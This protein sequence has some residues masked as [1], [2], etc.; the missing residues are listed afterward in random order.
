ME[1]DMQFCVSLLS[2]RIRIAFAMSTLGALSAGCD[3]GTHCTGND[4]Q[5]SGQEPMGECGPGFV[6]NDQ[7]ECVDATAPSPGPNPGPASGP[8]D[9][10]PCQ[11]AN[12]GTCQAV[13]ESYVCLCDPGFHDDGQSCV[14][15]DGC[16]TVV[17][18][19]PTAGESVGELYIRGE[20]N[21]WSQADKMQRR[22]DGSFVATLQLAA[23][24]WGYKLYD[25]S[26]DRW[27]EDPSNPY[28][29]WIGGIRNSRLHVRDCN[30]PRLLLQARPQ[31]TANSVSWQVRFVDGPGGGGLDAPSV[32]VTRNGVSVTASVDAATSTI[33]L[34][35]T[36]LPPGKYAYYLR[37]KDT[38]G[39]QAPRLYVPVWVQA[40]PFSWQDAI[41]YF[42]L[43]D[44]FANGNPGNDA[45]VDGVDWRANWEGGDFAGLKEKIEEGYFNTLGV[46]TLWLSSVVQ[47]TSGAGLGID[48]DNHLYAAYHSYWPISTGW[49]EGHELPGVQPVDPHFGTLAELKELVRVAHAQGLRVIVDLVANHVHRDSPLWQQHAGDTPPWFHDLYVCG[50]DQP[51][52][53][54]FADYLPDFDYTN[55][56]VLNTVVE[57]AVWLVEETDVDGFRLDAVKHMVHDFAR[58]LRGRLNETLGPSGQRF[59]I[60]GETFVG[61]GDDAAQLIRDYVSP[62]ELDGQFDFPLYWQVVTAFLREERSFQSVASTLDQLDGFFGNAAVMSNFLG[63]HDVPRALSHAAGDIGDMWGNGS[64]EQGWNAP[65]ALPQNTEPYRRLQMAWTFIMTI[66]GIPLIYYGDEFGMEGAGDPDNRHFM[67]FGADLNQE[68]QAV[69]AH[70]EKLT[71]ARSA[72]R[73]FRQGKRKQL[74]MDNDG[75][76]WAYG[77]VDSDD[78]GLV[79]LNRKGG[80]ETRHISVGSLGWNDGTALVDI[81]SGSHYTIAGG[82]ID[83]TLEGHGSAVLLR[84]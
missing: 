84:E 60:V 70:V 44:R 21:D 54:W 28:V 77:M 41:L 4:C 55:F 45:P 43:T 64:K 17:S 50:W 81:V 79:A 3:M 16:D 51:I 29:K 47:N 71:A 68:Q 24:D 26:G 30:E 73:A 5:M 82:A 83:L 62:Q 76:F 78:A 48:G 25:A 22:N 75:L 42:V 53:C 27:F 74:Y 35:D 13:G 80:S 59:Y 2:P 57:H 67:R 72:H 14:A 34:S 69:L 8:C 15:A 23:G 65:P 63:N 49:R 7:Q 61:E 32:E 19:V 20:F 11:E 52:N 46:N 37:A 33:A 9:A 6:L 56:D 38:A 40:Q 66:P 10:N 58:A 39:R 18:Y 36:D 1:N 31:A 12:R